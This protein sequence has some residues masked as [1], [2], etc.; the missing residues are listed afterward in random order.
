VQVGIAL[1][2]AMTGHVDRNAIDKNCHIRTVIG[3][4]TAQKDL[5]RF[6][7]A[8]DA[9]AIKRP[10]TSRTMSLGSTRTEFEIFLTNCLFTRGRCWL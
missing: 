10:G 1:A 8:P 3:I 7:T 6:A 9:G 4:K 5:V 2:V